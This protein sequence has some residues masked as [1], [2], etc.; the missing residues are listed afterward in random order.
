MDRW[1]GVV[2]DSNKKQ[3]DVQ[4]NWVNILYVTLIEAAN[5]GVSVWVLVQGL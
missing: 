3:S 1:A 4:T 5:F 2:P